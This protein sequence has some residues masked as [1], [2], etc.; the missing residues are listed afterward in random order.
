VIGSGK[1]GF[2]RLPS[3]Q[4]RITFTNE[5][6]DLAAEKNNILENGSGVA[7]GD[8]DGDGWVDLYFC[9]LEG[10]NVLYRNLGNWSFEDI[11][12]QAGVGCPGQF[13]TGA[14]LADVDGDGDL[15]LLVNA[16]GGGTRLFLNDGRGKFTE[17]TESGL[18]NRFGAHSL[19]LA[20]IDGDGDLDLYVA[21]YR[22]TSFKGL[23]ESTKIRLRSINGRLT[24]PPEHAE[25]FTLAQTDAG[26]A[27]VELGEPDVLYLNDGRGHFT[28]E[29]WTSGRFLD[30]AG[31]SLKEPPRD[32]GLSAMF[33]DMNGDGFP[34][35][36]VCNDF[37]SPDRIWINDGTGHFR[38]APKLAVR[39]TSFASMAV[40]FGDLNRDGF[41]DFLVVDMLSRHHLER[42]FQRSNFELAPVPW[43]G[44]PPDRE[45]IDGRPQTMRN[46][47]FLNRGDGTF[48][49]V[50]YAAGV[51]A[52]EWSWGVIFMDV[53][54]DGW[55][56]ILIS[57]GHGHDLTD[58]DALRR[59]A[60]RPPT[61]GDRSPF[62]PLFPRLAR[63]HVAYRNLG[64]RG[65]EEVGRE[66][67]FAEVGVGQGMAVGDL[68]NDGDLDVVIN[69]LNGEAT[70][71]R[72]EGSAPRV[73]VRLQG[74]GG[75]TQGI[76]ARVRLR[77]GPVEQ[78][79]EVIS[80]GRYLSGADP[81][82]V[83]AAGGGTNLELEV[84]WRSGRRSVVRG[85]QANHLYEVAEAG[86]EAVP[87]VVPTNAAPWYEEASLGHGHHEEPFDDFARQPL[88]P[89]RLSQ[90]GPGVAWFDL[91]GDGLEDLIIG[92]GRGGTLAV[93]A[94]NG[95]GGFS[96]VK[97]AVWAGAAADDLTGVVA[98]SAEAGA[99]TLLVGQAN[100]ETGG[101]NR[102]AVL[103][104]DVFFGEIK[105]GTNLAGDGASVGPL[106]VADLDG[107][108]ELE[109]FVG[110]RVEGGRYPQGVSSR[111][112]RQ[113]GGQLVLDEA[114][115][116]VLAGVGLVSG[117]VWSDLDG[118]GYPELV[119]ACEWGPV[120]VFANHRGQLSEATEAWGLAGYRG[121][122]SGVTAGDFDGDGRMDLVAGNWGRNSPYEEGLGQEPRL[123]HGDVD[124]NGTWDVVEAQWD[125][126]LKAV[127]PRRDW[128]S[129]GAAIPWVRER[130]GSYREYG[131]ASVEQIYGAKLGALSELRVNTLDTMLFLNRG[132]R[133]AAHPL[134]REA[135]MA[136]V[137]GLCVGDYDG[138]GREDL[139]VGQNFFGTDRETGRLDAG[140]GL[141][142]RGDGHGGLES[143][144]GSASGVKVSGEQRG[145]ALAD[146][147]GDGRVDLVVSQNGAATRLY[148]NVRGRP[149]VRVRVA[150][151]PGNVSGWGTVLRLGSA[152]Q[153]GPA[154]E[155]HCGAGY[156]SQD[157]PVT[158]LAAPAGAG[159]APLRLWARWPG[160]KHT[161]ASL[162][163]DAHEVRLHF[164]GN[165]EKIR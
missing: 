68:D 123:Y 14:V 29:S 75:N 125:G 30:E 153:P 13:S 108:G 136:P 20:D 92:S 35:L 74:A 138:D 141:W 31:R 52:S 26:E 11:T 159:D 118:D 78:S 86:A 73:A 142:L 46:T 53:D 101:T 109:V 51:S 140:R 76:G 4:T 8:V 129:V 18:L 147:D 163:P 10:P 55:E 96:A 134:P 43:W 16:L 36:Y 126:E 139:F 104:Y 164:N 150:G 157:S 27:L 113:R 44:W 37:F 114:N 144:S 87:A 93:L 145:A 117:A 28:P 143:I 64:G 83:F 1:T 48:A 2:I 111:L 61:A 146:Y 156:W 152:E 127:V 72:N 132:G 23:V 135:Q 112:Y 84:Q 67:G 33:H 89:R 124:G 19:A 69:N 12:A 6:A 25:Q 154:R 3:T 121:W 56:D 130:F 148:H 71:L 38:A 79:Q 77:G 41:D 82:R 32:W 120:R 100:Y 80:G 158:V 131:R 17:S 58:S 119:L 40:D 91:N 122:W 49:E 116:R 47:L 66:W 161:E 97:R 50:A 151:P 94:G 90:L 22:T 155:L 149:G 9:R 7:V 162:P 62:L 45:G 106:A 160:G 15:D 24:V 70:I 102:P 59:L 99:S 98:W 128:Q 165:L 110:G 57:N 107:D 65:F 39:K 60:A 95:R 42:M 133:F 137:Y 81:L 63:P 34:D 5:L 54:L 85:V 115:S 88:L 21:N 103:R 105:A